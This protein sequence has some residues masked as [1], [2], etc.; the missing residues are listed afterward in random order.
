MRALCKG[1]CP[2]TCTSAQLAKHLSVFPFGRRPPAASLTAR[3]RTPATLVDV[4]CCSITARPPPP[5]CLAM[6]RGGEVSVPPRLSAVAGP[7]TG[8]TG[9][10]SAAHGSALSHEEVEYCAEEELVTI[11]PA[12]RKDVPLALLSGQY[13]PFRPQAR[14]RSAPRVSAWREGSLCFC[15]ALCA[16]R[17]CGTPRSKQSKL[18]TCCAARGRLSATTCTNALSLSCELTT[19]FGVV[20][21]VAAPKGAHRGAIMDGR[22]AGHARQV[23][24]PAAAVDGAACFGGGAPQGARV[25]GRVPGAHAQRTPVRFHVSVCV[26]AALSTRRR[27]RAARAAPPHRR[28]PT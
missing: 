5:C 24:H 27:T 16:A 8:G 28:A 7:S 1:R 2:L 10:S 3:P 19:C 17:R 11:V 20:L 23:H 6:S 4:L 26:R 18:C 9:W 15:G 12:F 14:R 22:C 25:R 21:C 13:G